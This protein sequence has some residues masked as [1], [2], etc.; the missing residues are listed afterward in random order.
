MSDRS[1]NRIKKKTKK[2][3]L[4][5]RMCNVVTFSEQFNAEAMVSKETASIRAVPAPWQQFI[6]RTSALMSCL[7]LAEMIITSAKMLFQQ[8]WA[9]PASPRSP[10]SAACDHLTVGGSRKQRDFREG[11]NGQKSLIQAK[12]RSVF[13]KRGH[14]FANDFHPQRPLCSHA[15]LT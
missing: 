7:L 13:S 4:F 14:R 10:P 5:V 3:I 2:F 12:R 9:Y 11:R 6:L 8:V 15:A 1:W